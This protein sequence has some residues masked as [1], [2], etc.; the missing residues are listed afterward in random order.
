MKQRDYEVILACIQYGAPA[1]AQPLI[2]ALNS[3]INDS[4]R[5]KAEQMQMTN[6]PKEA[7][8]TDE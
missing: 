7:L 2:D 6:K 1:L 5:W 3:V 4:N 8:N